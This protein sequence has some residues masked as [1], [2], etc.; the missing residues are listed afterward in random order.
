[1]VKN[2]ATWLQ[3]LLYLTSQIDAFAEQA[4][5]S[6]ALAGRNLVDAHD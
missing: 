2:W 3:I 5:I 4:H 1:M 6:Y